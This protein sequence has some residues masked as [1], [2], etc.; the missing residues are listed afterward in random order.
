MVL[1]FPRLELEHFLVISGF[2]TDIEFDGTVYHV[3]TE[4]KGL[5]S[6]VIMSL[7][8]QKGT[9]LASKRASYDDLAAIGTL[10]EKVLSDRV[11]KQHKLI[12][13]AVKAGRIDDLKKMSANGSAGK[14]K[15]SRKAQSS[16][17]TDLSFEA[18]LEPETAAVP[19]PVNGNSIPKPTTPPVPVFEAAIFQTVVGRTDKASVA[20]APPG[21]KMTGQRCLLT[22]WR[23][24]KTSRSFPLTPSK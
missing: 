7:V 19:E 8:Y 13:T 3:Q 12:C 23:S 10:D 18:Q 15:I 17:N 9:I 14:S 20:E 4:D 1:P 11:Q 22:M 21:Q 6:K 5:S 24:S 2:N 16:V